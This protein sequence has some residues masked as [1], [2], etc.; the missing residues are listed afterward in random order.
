MKYLCLNWRWTNKPISIEPREKEWEKNHRINISN[1]LLVNECYWIQSNPSRTI[2]LIGIVKAS[3]IHFMWYFW[4]NT[5]NLTLYYI[6]FFRFVLLWNIL[7]YEP[8]FSM[9]LSWNYHSLRTSVR[10]SSAALLFPQICFQSGYQKISVV[11]TL[12]TFRARPFPLF[13]TLMSKGG[14]MLLLFCT[15]LYTHA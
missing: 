12:A 2:V 13:A 10:S 5:F 1:V 4:T 9:Y 11:S 8:W 7:K 14:L 6:L 15:W 3:K